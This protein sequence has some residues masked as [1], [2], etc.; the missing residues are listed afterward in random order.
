[1]ID[2]RLKTFLTLCEYKNYRKTAEALSITQPAVTQHIHA[3]ENH[4]QCKLF[5]YDKHTLTITGAGEQ[6]KRY[7]ENVLYQEEKVMAQLTKPKKHRLRIG[8]TKTIG[9]YVIPNMIM[10]F[11]SNPENNI[12]VEVDNTDHLLDQLKEGLL[13]FALIEGF[14]DRSEFSSMLYRSEKFVGV[15]SREHPFAG[16]TIDYRQIFSEHLILRESGSG[17]RTIL[18]QLL[19][20]HNCTIS[21]F[22]RVSYISNFGL[23]AQL[24]EQ[25]LGITFAYESFANHYQSLTFFKIRGWNT[26]RDFNYVF[27][28]APQAREAVEEFDK[29]RS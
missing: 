3:L 14:F 6:L 29:M 16:K 9:E 22:D 18:E 5:L 19:Q 1:M 26:V 12:S 13:D 28:D 11:L 4:Y 24:I 8:A 25:G 21:Q 20:A 2:Y 15:C 23:M 7:A 27:F 17:T 10:K